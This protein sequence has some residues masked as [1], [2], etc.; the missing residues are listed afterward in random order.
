M[1]T[2]QNNVQLIGHLGD[3]P[4]EVKLDNNKKLAKFS[5]ATNLRY[6]NKEGDTVENTQWHRIVAWDKLA[7]ICIKHLK[8]GSHVACHG[9]L[10][11]RDYETKS[12][13]KRH[14]AEI[15]L[16]EMLML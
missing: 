14:S 11:Y 1:S 4:E 5:L 15:H 16:D 13:E 7:D 12:G 6:K 2:I 8:K 9:R 3:D 10:V